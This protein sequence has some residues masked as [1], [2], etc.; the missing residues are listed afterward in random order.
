VQCVFNCPVRQGYGLTETCA[1][2]CVGDMA[3]NSTGNVGPPSPATYIR[4]RDWEEGGYTNADRD[5][6]EI[7]MP[8]GEVLIGGPTVADGYLVDP[9]NP[10]ADV[11]KK[12]EEDFVTIA[13]VR[14]FCS[15]D[16]GQVTD[17]GCLQ[18]ID[19]KKDL[20]K[21]GNGEY[22]SLSKVEALLKLSPYVEMPMVYGKTGAPS[23]IALV[24]PQKPAIM[25][26]ASKNSLTGTFDELCKNP[27]VLAEVSKSCVKQC[28]AGGLNGFE[29]PTALSLLVGPD[30]GPAWSPDNEM[31]TTTLKLKRP[32][33][34]KA[35]AADIDDCY[36]RSAK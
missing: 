32:I 14:Y 7:G 28:K 6:A 22:V 33:I 21:G 27:A 13:G 24:C 1:A 36:A 23:V 30:G 19:R 16:I 8:R 10:D 5:K 20:F 29:I 3:D 17:R 35:F 11:V 26:F 25:D 2:S 4:L 12:N 31:L 18:I 15:G 34:A 9:S